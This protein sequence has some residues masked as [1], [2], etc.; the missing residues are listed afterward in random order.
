MQILLVGN[1][2]LMYFLNKGWFDTLMHTPVGQIILAICGAALFITTAT[3][4]KLTQPIE[5]RR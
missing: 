3:V 5:Y 4:I 1:I 2:P